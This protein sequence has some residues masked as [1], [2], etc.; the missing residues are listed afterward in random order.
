VGYISDVIVEDR[1]AELVVFIDLTAAV[2]V[3]AVTVVEVNCAVKLTSP[4]DT[5]GV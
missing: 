4:V 3:N 5:L 1:G 2:A